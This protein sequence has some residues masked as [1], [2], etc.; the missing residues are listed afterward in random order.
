MGQETDAYGV[1]EILWKAEIP[2]KP[3]VLLPYLL[4]YKED[5][6]GMRVFC[7]VLSHAAFLP[8][9]ALGE[10]EGCIGWSVYD[11]GSYSDFHVC[12]RIVNDVSPSFPIGFPFF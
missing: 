7:S 5:V 11:L 12:I 6:V 9:I 2:A 3:F 1:M 8:R 4:F 10:L